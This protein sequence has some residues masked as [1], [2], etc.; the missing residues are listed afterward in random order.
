MSTATGLVRRPG[1]ALLTSLAIFALALWIEVLL[2]QWTGR[3]V[4]VALAPAVALAAWLGGAATALTTVAMSAIAADYYLLGPGQLLDLRGV[5][6]AA[7]ALFTVG[8]TAV[9]LVTASASRRVAQER[10]DRQAAE[11]VAAQAHRLAQSTA[12]LGQVRTSSEAIAAALHES[13]HWLKAGAGIFYLLTDDRER[14]TIAQVAGYQLNEGDCC[15]LEAFGDDSP[16]TEAMRRLTPVVT[17]SAQSRSVEYEEWSNAGP[18]RDRA[19]GV[20]MPIAIERRVVAFLQIDFDMPREFTVDDHEFIHSICSRTAQALNRVW[21]HESV[22]RARYDAETLKDRA[23]LELVERQK[24]ELALRSSETRYRALATRTTRLHTLT[25]SLSESVSVTAVANAIVEQARIVVG[26]ADANLKLLADGTERPERGL[27]AAEAVASGRPVFVG[28]LA[29]S[30]EKYWLSARIAADNGYESVAALPLMVKDRP[31]GVLEFHFSAPVN[32]DDEYQAL[33]ISVAQHSTQALDRARLY[34]Q[35]ER[36]RAEAERANRL[37]DEFVSTVSHELRTPLNAILGWA[38]MLRTE[39]MDRDVLP[40]AIDSIYRNASRQAKLVDDLLDFARMDTGRMSLELDTID[41]PN[42]IRGIVESVN[43]LAAGNQ[44]NIKLTPIPEATLR[45]DVKRL[46]QVFVN[47][48]GNSL[49]F[50]PP[51]GHIMVSARIVSRALEIRVADTGIGIEP[52]FLPFVFD[53]FR[54]GD[55]TTT[56][57]HSGLG[58]GLS[59]A[60]QLVEAHKG[61]IRAESGGKGKGTAFIVTLPISGQQPAAAVAAVE[62]EP[63]VRLDGVRV[64]V[65]DD[66]KDT[67]DLIGRA[68]EDRGAHIS[69]AGNSQ[70]AIDILERNEIDVLLADIAMP[71]EDGYSLIQRIR[72]AGTPLASIPAAAVTAHARDD[73]RSRA[74]AAGFHVHMA[75]PVEPSEIVRMVDHLAH[76]RRTARRSRM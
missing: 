42:L 48:I 72:A 41:V 68:L 4:F 65:V 64:L 45:G 26:A 8:W 50:T 25:A 20:V 2:S 61:T 5:D 31:L 23:D 58:L 36:A 75:K 51:G 53:R 73:E 28:S 37:K 46:E 32:F 55:G 7:L 1:R 18:W 49:K 27:C 43:P 44:I 3:F 54:Q 47:L 56:R 15:E 22:E 38:S 33:L 19:A 57:N 60:K 69:V 10:A 12:A 40:Q 67:R 30:Q 59:I 16:F 6:A 63:D 9:A 17:A 11:R 76:D 35:A 74:L 21:W 70:D 71:D 39:S 14:L 34:E 13:L 52:E 62:P 24:T 66:E 29:E